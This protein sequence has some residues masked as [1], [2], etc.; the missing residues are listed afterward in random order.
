MPSDLSKR[1]LVE[2]KSYDILKSGKLDFEILKLYDIKNWIESN[3][4]KKIFSV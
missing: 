1:N 3:L 4:D 2:F